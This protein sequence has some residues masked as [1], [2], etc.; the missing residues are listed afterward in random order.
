[1]SVPI[2]EMTAADLKDVLAFWTTI[3]GIG[4]GESDTV[5][6]LDSFLRRNV[7]LS[8]LARSEG[9]IVAAVLCGHDGRRGYL[10]HL[11]VAESHRRQRIGTILVD[12]C[13]SILALIAIPKCNIF[14]F[15]DND[16]GAVFWRNTHWCDRGDL[17]VLQRPTSAA[18]SDIGNV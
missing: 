9:R 17:R 10:H 12:R 7:G 8:L 15:A 18:I 11:A 2:V 16:K 4:L 6:H 13:L 5:E 14:L 3:E 1:M